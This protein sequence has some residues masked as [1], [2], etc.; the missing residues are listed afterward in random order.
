MSEEKIKVS[1]LVPVYG[2]EKSIGRCVRT[3]FEQT[4]TDGIEFI[5]TNDC[6]ED[7]SIEIVLKIL[8]EYPH[9][10]NQVKII[11]HP[12]NLGL[13]EARVTGL[14]AARGEYVIH[15]DSDDYMAREMCQLMYEEGKRTQA[16]IVGCDSYHV[17]PSSIQLRREAFD[18]PKKEL[19]TE[20]ILDRA[21]GAYLWNRM[22]KR[23]F[24]LNG[25]FRAETGT[26]LLE[27]MA[28][29]LPMHIAAS[30][31]AYLSLPLYYYN[32]TD[33]TSMSGRM[34]NKNIDSAVSVLLQLSKLSLTDDWGSALQVR[35]RSFLFTRVMSFR[36]RNPEGWREVELPYLKTIEVELPLIHRLAKWLGEHRFDRVLYIVMLGNKLFNPQVWIEGIKILIGGKND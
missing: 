1:V 29:T 25:K 11:N 32:R 21:V 24:Y 20:L 16:D 26:T 35:M 9:R 12:E 5:F 23:S 22:I 30:K 27:D 19:I 7:R 36:G 15:C 28:V 8:E 10:K 31:V 17:F 18:Y 33:I 4:L 3:L 2:V 13:A 34:T 6:T 14:Q